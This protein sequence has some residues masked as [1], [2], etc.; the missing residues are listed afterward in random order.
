MRI[1][2]RSFGRSLS[3]KRS[4]IISYFLHTVLTSQISG[5]YTNRLG[6]SP[7]LIQTYF[8]AAGQ[9]FTIGLYHAGHISCWSHSSAR[10]AKSLKLTLLEFAGSS[11]EMFAGEVNGTYV[12][13]TG[14]SPPFI[15][16]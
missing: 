10:T 16:V 2:K 5:A 3:P 1:L 13:T 4:I 15:T 12:S 6:I 9:L 7:E 8:L 14:R 11:S